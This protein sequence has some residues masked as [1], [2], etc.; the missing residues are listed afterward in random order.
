[1]IKPVPLKGTGSSPY[2]NL[3][4]SKG[5]EPMRERSLKEVR[6]SHPLNM[7]TIIQTLQS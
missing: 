5:L 7:D 3:V 6:R 1:M 2:I 4:R